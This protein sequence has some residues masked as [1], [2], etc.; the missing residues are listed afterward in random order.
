M[1]DDI[2]SIRLG[3]DS[4]LEVLEWKQQHGTLTNL[5]VAV[6]EVS[7]RFLFR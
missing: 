5:H 6:F 3:F 4:P 2:E 1:A 7:C